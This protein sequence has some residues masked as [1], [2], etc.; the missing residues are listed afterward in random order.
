[1]PLPS[2]LD[3]T[4]VRVGIHH[5]QGR[6]AITQRFEDRI[7]HIPVINAPNRRL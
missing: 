6:G 2:A 7:A 3:E 5:Q 1:M 4:G